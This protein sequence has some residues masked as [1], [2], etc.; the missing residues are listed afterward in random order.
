MK[1]GAILSDSAKEA[2]A[3]A[4]A[5]KAKAKALRPWF[6]KKRFLF[7]IVLVVIIAF[8]MATRGGGSS[9]N[10]A[11]TSGSSSTE[12]TSEQAS[13]NW[14]TDNYANFAAADF[15]GKGDDVFA[16][17]E[18][19]INGLIQATYKGSS[20]FVIEVIDSGNQTADL[21]VNTIGSYSGTTSYG[22]N[23]LGGDP[24]K[25]KVTASGA[26]TIKI[27]P[28]NDASTLPESG[29]GDGVFKYEDTNAP[30]WL[31]T[32]SG[33]SN[34]AVSQEADSALMG[35]L[36]NEIG[37]YKGTVPAYAGPSIVTIT[38]DGKWTITAK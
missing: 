28:F 26:W 9:S 4:K 34:F 33:Q 21:A 16:L 35:L 38:A 17:P 37:N 23:S 8:S 27:A 30:T 10:D 13:S 11:G 1:L 2:K 6:K 36:I 32:H 12:S 24:A 31:V 15:S 29:K 20:N 7:P 25:V 22:L 14:Y 5:A 18:G 3:E 19:A